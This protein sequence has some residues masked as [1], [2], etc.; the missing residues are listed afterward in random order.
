MSDSSRLERRCA[1]GAAATLLVH[2]LSGV[3]HVRKSW[4]SNLAARRGTAVLGLLVPR[5]HLCTP[6]ELAKAAVATGELRLDRGARTSFLAALEKALTARALA[7]AAP[8]DLILLPLGL[9]RVCTGR[10]P[11][12][13]IV[14]ADLRLLWS[15]LLLGV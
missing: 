13:V 15:C 14:R 2:V 4:Q 8:T 10:D 3:A 1:D 12:Q 5:L 11:Y 9:S 6:A 7:A